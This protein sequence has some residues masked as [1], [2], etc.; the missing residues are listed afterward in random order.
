MKQWFDVM[1]KS[2]IGIIH[3][4]NWYFWELL[5]E[6]NSKEISFLSN[7]WKNFVKK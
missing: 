6:L 5:E 2:L 1:Q 3:T 7:C 4:I